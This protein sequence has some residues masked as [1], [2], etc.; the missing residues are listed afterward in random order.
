MHTPFD[1][2]LLNLTWQHLLEGGLVLGASHTHVSRG[3][4]TVLPNFG[5][6]FLFMHTPFD[7]ELPIFT[8]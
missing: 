4:A 3:G 1:A 7:A 2:E 6:S 8:R 5:G